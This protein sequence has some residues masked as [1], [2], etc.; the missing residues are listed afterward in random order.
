MF[1]KKNAVEVIHAKTHYPYTGLTELFHDENGIVQLLFRQ[2]RV[3][4]QKKRAEVRQ[5]GSVRDYNRDFVPGLAVRGRL[6]TA[7]Q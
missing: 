3:H 1:G 4:V 6:M 2:E 7:L 5:P